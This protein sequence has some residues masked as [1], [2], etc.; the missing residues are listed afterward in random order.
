MHV[1]DVISEY[2]SYPKTSESMSVT[3]ITVSDS[4]TSRDLADWTIVWKM[5]E[6]GPEF[7]D[8]LRAVG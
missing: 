8:E 2:L 5:F 4:F 7:F 1:S 6:T 3:M